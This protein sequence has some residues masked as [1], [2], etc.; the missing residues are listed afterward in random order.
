[1][2]PVG[3]ADAAPDNA[4]PAPRSPAGRLLAAIRTD[5]TLAPVLAAVRER[6][7]TDPAHDLDHLLRVADWTL[8]LVDDA[9][10]RAWAIAAALLHDVVN[11][12]KAD[13][14]RGKASEQSAAAADKLLATLGWS[15]EARAAITEAIRQHS[16]SRGETPTAPLAV[17][18]RDADR[19]EAL[20]VLGLFRCISTGVVFGADYVDRDDPWAADRALDDRRHSIDHLFVK[21]F[22]VADGLVLPRARAEGARR[23]ATMQQLCT[24]LGDELGVPWRPES[25]HALA[26]ESL[27]DR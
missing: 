8:T 18:L 15:P 23:V 20:G 12:S 5:D 27:G 25:A 19:L 2:S 3:S 26:V 1:M 7:R 16:W 11:V 21:L 13:P 4:P 14:A 10:P 9:V 6:M 24:A 17:A 22:R